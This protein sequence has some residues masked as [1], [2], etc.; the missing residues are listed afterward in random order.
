M[1]EN[2]P[3][4][5]FKPMVEGDDEMLLSVSLPY[6]PHESNYQVKIPWMIGMNSAEGAFKAARKT[7]LNI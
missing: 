1:W 4:P 2:E 3:I 7:L 5:F 6:L